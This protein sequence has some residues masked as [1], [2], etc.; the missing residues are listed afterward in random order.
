MGE[1]YILLLWVV[2]KYS[3]PLRLTIHVIKKTKMKM[4]NSILKHRQP[5]P[6]LLDF[7]SDLRVVENVLHKERKG[8]RKKNEQNLRPWDHLMQQNK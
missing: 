1:L 6:T 2:S 5:Q 3:A 7:Q 4:M 8:K